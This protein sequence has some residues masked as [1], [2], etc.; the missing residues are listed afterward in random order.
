MKKTIAANRADRELDPTVDL[1]KSTERF[2]G[3]EP[4]SSYVLFRMS[5]DWTTMHKLAG[6]GFLADTMRSGNTWLQ[7]YIHPDDQPHVMDVIQK[8]IRT[9]NMFELEYRV[10]RSDGSLIWILSR[11]VPL[12]DANEEISEWFGTVSDATRRILTEELLAKQEAKYR[13][14]VETSA[15]GFWMVDREG[16]ILMVND[17]YMRRSGYS[18]EGLMSMSIHDLEAQESPQDVQAHIDRVIHKGSDLFETRHRTKDGEIWPVEISTSF[19][20]VDGGLFFVFSRDLT[21]RNALKRG[22]IEAGAAEQERIGR[23][24][25]DGLGQQLTGISLLASSLLDRLKASGRTG[26]ADSMAELRGYIQS[27]LG[28]LRALVRGLAPVELDP[29]G[30]DKALSELTARIA[31]TTGIDCRYYGPRNI[32][33]KKGSTAIHLYRITQEAIQNAVKH[34]EPKRIDVCLERVDRNLVLTVSDDGKGI[35]R[36]QEHRGGYGLHIMGYRCS[37]IGGQLSIETP[38]GRG[39][40]VRCKIPLRR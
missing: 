11:A 6:K 3:K 37:I 32:D 17:S 40:L 39:T 36:N 15:D 4:A 7:Q 22:I 38:E 9:K 24:L 21:E 28:E 33:V 18:R 2:R 10:P 27:A 14:V 5:P 35:H 1:S 30:L 16:H 13:A 26:E 25:H 19:L 34:A 23:E 31:S 8:A 20:P 12:L 29:M